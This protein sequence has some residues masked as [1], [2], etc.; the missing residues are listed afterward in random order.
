MPRGPTLT[1]SPAL[2]RGLSQTRSPALTRG[3]PEQALRKKKTFHQMIFFLILYTASILF[4]SLLFVA[5]EKTVHLM[6]SDITV[7]RPWTIDSR[8]AL[9][10]GPDRVNPDLP[11][12][13]NIEAKG[14]YTLLY[15]NLNYHNDCL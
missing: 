1:W 6:V 3:P 4:L 7:H 13:H 12:V 5:K 11:L 9:P 14:M 15:W 10:R 2:T 8:I